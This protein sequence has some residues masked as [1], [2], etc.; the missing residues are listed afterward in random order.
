MDVVPIDNRERD[1]DDETD[2]FRSMAGTFAKQKAEET[3]NA[4]FPNGIATNYEV[5][6]PL[7]LFRGRPCRQIETGGEG[8]GGQ[9]EIHP[10]DRAIADRHVGSR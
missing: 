4:H 8:N 10:E 1:R 3:S 6:H 9:N 2:A 7:A 5:L